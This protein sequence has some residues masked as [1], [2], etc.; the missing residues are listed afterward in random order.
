[1]LHQALANGQE[2][3]E[4]ALTAPSSVPP[5]SELKPKAS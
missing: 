4:L 2:Q 3:P 5:I 1:M